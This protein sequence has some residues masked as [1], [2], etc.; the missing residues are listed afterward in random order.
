M[1]RPKAGRRPIGPGQAGRC[2][3]PA[4]SRARRAGQRR[5]SATFRSQCTAGA[6]VL[7]SGT[8]GPMA[9]PIRWGDFFRHSGENRSPSQR[10]DSGFRRNDGAIPVPS[11]GAI[12]VPSD[13]AMPMPPDGA[14][15]K[16][17]DGAIA[18]PPDGAIAKPPDGAMPKPPDGAMPMPPDGAMPKPPDGAMPMP[19]D[20]AMPMPPEK[21]H[22]PL[23]RG[24]AGCRALPR[25]ES[26]PA[27][28][29]R[30]SRC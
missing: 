1:P 15:A 9:F 2:R 30:S 10:V 7:S 3:H 14:I 12:P 13:G 28:G 4:V 20:G 22:Y 5:R 16:P 29:R 23:G 8:A 27:Q 25:R 18:K 26:G 19:P 24:A 17:P 21:N 11:D 6:G